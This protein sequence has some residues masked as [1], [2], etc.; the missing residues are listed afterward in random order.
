MKISQK[1]I[2]LVSIPLLFELIFVASLAFML[3]QADSQIERLAESQIITAEANSL[4]NSVLMTG[5]Q[6]VAY[7]YMH[8]EQVRKRLVDSIAKMPKMLEHLKQLTKGDER[9][10]RHVT[11]ME[12]DMR[13]CSFF[14]AQYLKL[15]IDQG[16]SDFGTILKQARE[17]ERAINSL[18]AEAQALT[19][20]EEAIQS[21]Y[22]GGADEP[23]RK[24]RT[25][26]WT[27]VSINVLITIL[28]ALFFS[29]S[30]T[31]RLAILR[32][33]AFLLASR[34][35]LLPHIAGNDEITYLDSV[36][37]QVAVE[38]TSAEQ[39]KQEFVSM[40]SH[41]L[42]TPLTSLQGT[43]ALFAN[44]AYG[45]LSTK[46]LKRVINA[47]ANVF[48]LIGLIN[49]LL[50]IDKIEAGMLE[51][52][53]VDVLVVPMVMKAIEAVQIFAEQNEI[54]IEEPNLEQDLAVHADEG[55]IIQV[56]VNLLSNAI[57]YSEPGKTVRTNLVPMDGFAEIQIIDAGFGIPIEYRDKI[58]DRFQRIERSQEKHDST[59]LGLA[60]SKAFIEGSGGQIGVRSGDAQGST[61]WFR[62]PL[63][64]GVES[65][66]AQA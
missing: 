23:R 51:L 57:K 66:D 56:L 17:T 34:K 18:A 6:V 37:H 31:S 42:R 21:A 62:L 45:D 4:T 10:L 12:Q 38:L 48:R 8:K 25:F 49:Q 13:Q 20:E 9:R 24:V 43:L 65:P 33:N 19:R 35:P 14:F 55:R 41:D 22:P 46:A 60:I 54:S 15:G 64:G 32:A 30:I 63:A 36:F 16:E 59:G 39:R 28:M 1:G 11:R 5:T 29:K 2:V 26:L 52:H 27:A 61:F 53:P 47:E 40:I 3:N 44:G 7:R 50:D 58:F